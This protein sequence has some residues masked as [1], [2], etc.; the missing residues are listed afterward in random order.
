[1]AKTIYFKGKNI[2]NTQSATR[3]PFKQFAVLLSVLF[4]T[5]ALSPAP[6]SAQTSKE[7]GDYL[8]YQEQVVVGLNFNELR[9]SKY[10]SVVTSFVKGNPSLGEVLA[11]L[12][13]A[14][15]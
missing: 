13:A 3:R 4:L 2:L 8:S 14:G 10:Y 7:L 15:L 9:K 11:T 6:A 12:D 1:M 5:L